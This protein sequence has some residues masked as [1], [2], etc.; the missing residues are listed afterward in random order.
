MKSKKMIST[1]I[2]L[3]ITLIAYAVA[4][5]FF[6][7][8]TKPQVT[9]GKFPFSITYEYK[10]ETR[11]LSGVFECRFDGSQTVGGEHNR[12]WEGKTIYANA[13]H[14]ETPYIV[15][16]DDE[17]QTTLSVQENMSAGYFMGDPLYQDYYAQYGMEQAQPFVEYYDYR[18]NISLD[19]EN[20]DAILQS[21]GFKILDVTYGQPI[22]NDFSFAGIRYEADNISV[23]IGISLA[24]LLLCLIFVRKE[25]EYNYTKLDKIGL[26]LNFVVGFVAL[27]FISLV[28]VFFGLVESNVALINQITYNIP[29]VTICCLALSVAFRRK[30]ISKTGFFVQFVGVALFVLILVADLLV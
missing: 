12:H 28:C 26:I 2:F 11:T 22:E 29:S 30:G 14:S 10:G 18:N 8:I 7:Y 25:Q 21:I 27:P 24:F 15:D 13:D 3:A 23:F 1:F 20:D 16:Q 4:S 19:G 5:V 17:K 9:Q 6:C